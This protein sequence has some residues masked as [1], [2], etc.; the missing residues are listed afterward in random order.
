M[1]HSTVAQIMYLLSDMKIRLQLHGKTNQRP[2]GIEAKVTA[3]LS[4]CNIADTL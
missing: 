3:Q 4:S 1:N 2:I